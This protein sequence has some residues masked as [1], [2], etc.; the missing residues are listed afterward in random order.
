MAQK[1]GLTSLYNH[2]YFQNRLDLLIKE[3][4]MKPLSLIIMDIDDFKS[5]DHTVI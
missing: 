4:A 3:N 1:D 2:A 5:N